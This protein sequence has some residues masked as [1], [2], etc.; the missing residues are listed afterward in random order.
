MFLRRIAGPLLGGVKETTGIVGLPVVPNA[1]EVLIGLYRKT[2]DAVQPIP[3]SAQYRKTVEEITQHRLAICN[4][5]ED[6][7]EIEKRVGNGQ[8]EQLI[9][10]AKDELTLIPKMAEWKPWEAPEGYKVQIMIEENDVP[11]HVPLH[12]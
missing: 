1:R 9:Q 4:E 10:Q 7:K 6:W 2:L 5:E 3:E 8:V 11:S 12:R